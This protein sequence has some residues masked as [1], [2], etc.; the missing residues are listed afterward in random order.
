M[1]KARAVGLSVFSPEPPAE[2]A[3]G[4]KVVSDWAMTRLI[5]IL[6]TGKLYLITIALSSNSLCVSSPVDGPER[7][8]DRAIQPQEHATEQGDLMNY[9][10]LHLFIAL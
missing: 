4:R 9:C 2:N 3:V 8:R 10:C 6:F 1:E 5:K 7:A